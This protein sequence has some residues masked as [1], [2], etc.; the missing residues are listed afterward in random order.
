MF[1]T[2]AYR[3]LYKTKVG[4][5][6]F[7]TSGSKSLLLLQSQFSE[8][9]PVNDPDARTF[10]VVADGELLP[11]K[12]TFYKCQLVKVPEMNKTHHMIKVRETNK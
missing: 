3:D 7:G 1:F 2:V 6:Q 9:T 12:E 11:R 4:I 5:I 10:D 8:E